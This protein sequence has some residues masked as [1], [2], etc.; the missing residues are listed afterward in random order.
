MSFFN[1]LVLSIMSNFSLPRLGPGGPA[2]GPRF[3]GT[4]IQ[5]L[6]NIQIDAKKM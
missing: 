4:K 6:L 5:S 1:C 3:I 2:G